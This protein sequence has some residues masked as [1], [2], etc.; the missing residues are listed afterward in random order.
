MEFRQ[1]GTV[2]S[3]YL[4]TLGAALGSIISQT[5]RFHNRVEQFENWWNN[6]YRASSP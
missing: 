6:I 1:K 4:P 3:Q 5:L 2:A